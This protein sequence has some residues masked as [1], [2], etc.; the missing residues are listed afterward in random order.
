LNKTPYHH[1]LSK[2]SKSVLIALFSILC[3]FQLSAV[4]AVLTFEDLASTTGASGITGPLSPGY[5]GFTWTNI[6]GVDGAKGYPSGSGYEN[7][8]VSGDI[9]MYNNNTSGTADTWTSIKYATLGGVFNYTGAFWTSAWMTT[10]AHTISF[11]GWAG[12]TKLFSSGSVILSK[13]TPTWIAL[14]WDGIDELKIK[15]STSTTWQSQWGMD[16]FTFTTATSSPVPEP[17][18]MFLFGFGLLGLAG[19]SRRKK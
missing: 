9:V 6:Q 16:N 18:T 14:N 13:A 7:G 5:Q 8:A 4:A 17:A 1:I 10:D 19:V 3:T 15:N 2:A 11:E 12:S